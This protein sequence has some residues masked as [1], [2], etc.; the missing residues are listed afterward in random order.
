[1]AIIVAY[2]Q[3]SES[4]EEEIDQSYEAMEMTKNQCKL[5]EIIIVMGDMN[6]KVGNESGKDIV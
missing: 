3:T 1:M 5:Q 4:T 2:A 6:A